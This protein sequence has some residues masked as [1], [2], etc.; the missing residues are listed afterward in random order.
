MNT[1]R[2][3]ESICGPNGIGEAGST[4]QTI[5]LA[6]QLQRSDEAPTGMRRWLNTLE[7]DYTYSS[8]DFDRRSAFATELADMIRSEALRPSEGAKV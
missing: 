7:A 2:F 6:Y 8:Q 4:V 3:D 5:L 1:K